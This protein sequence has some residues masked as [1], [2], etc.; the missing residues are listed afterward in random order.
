[1]GYKHG[2]WL[3][4][5]HPL[6]KTKHIPHFTVGC[7][8]EEKD[9][10]NLKKELSTKIGQTLNINVASKNGFIFED[11]RYPD[12]YNY[13]YV[14]GYNG[15]CNQW[16]KV[17]KIAENYKCNFSSV[18]HI[19]MQYDKV[20]KNLKPFDLDK[21]VIAECSFEVVNMYNENPLLWYLENK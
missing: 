19:S 16:N 14:W 20:K 9:A 1:M 5:K 10:F 17:K 18:I 11:N 7:F 13:L 6:L 12:D 15:S 21:D 4:S 3:V 8:M 2:V